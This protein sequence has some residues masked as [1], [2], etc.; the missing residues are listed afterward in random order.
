MRSL[1]KLCALGALFVGLGGFAAPADSPPT[2]LAPPTAS[3][4][5]TP[6]APKNAP[7][8]AAPA[9]THA[10]TADD[11]GAYFDGF[12][13]DAIR[14]GDVAGAVV[15]VVKDGQPLFERG[16]G[17][18]DVKTRKP[19]D[20]A[21]TLFRPGSISKT[22]TWTAVMQ[23]VQAGK[24]DL[25]ADINR[26][27]D[28][29]VPAYDGK[30][31]TMRQLMTHSP[32]FSD[33]A[34]GLIITDPKR[35]EP[36]GAVLKSAVPA[37]IFPPGQIPAYSNYGASLAGYIVE[38]VSGEPFDQYV[39]RH[40]FAPLGM[41]H[42]TFTQPLPAPFK[43]D[44]AEGYRVASAPAGKFEIVQLAPAGSLSASGGDMARFMIAQLND[45]EYQ[46]QRILEAKTAELMH[47][48]Q[49]RPVPGLPAMALGFYQEPGNGHRVIGH[50]GDLA[51]F[52]SDM[53]LYLDDHV[54][55]FLSF[56]SAGAQAAAHTIRADILRSFTARYIAPPPP[57]EPT[58]ASAKADAK[59][60][61]GRYVDTRRSDTGW[62]RIAHFLLGQG[63]IAADKDGV[64]TVSDFRGLNNKPK[65]W[66]EVGPFQYR[67]VGGD[68]RM[69]A[70]VENGKVGLVMT[71]DLPPVLALTPVSPVMS[72]SWNTPLFYFSLAVILIAGLGWPLAAIV[73][74]RYGH[75]FQLAGRPAMLY[76]LT[77]LTCAVDLLCVACW[78]AFLTYVEGSLDAASGATDWMLRGLQL[79]GVLG[80]LGAVAAVLNAATILRAG[81][82]GWWAKVSSVLIAA[83]C[84]AFVWFQLSL[85]LLTFALAY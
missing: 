32:G 59:T 38:R 80:A 25:D 1:A 40:I 35:L 10:L 31:L 55:L 21:T 2:R 26:Y 33:Q 71:D 5:A 68:S 75:S 82:R 14:R 43:P 66:R 23:Q 15:V 77:R 84:L 73:R 49:F 36:L 50:A 67:E 56:N 58:A 52:H 12:I 48:P 13:P 8:P 4:P 46:G 76:R 6:G 18:A 47:S 65:H 19:V 81:D 69:A 3:L 39:A 7:T 62:L 20:P 42:S 51:N 30:P 34:K 37:R 61:A 27:L 72:A 24:I 16:Y 70:T 17:W 85:H 74:R 9:S 28:F 22:F 53:H 57:Q 83:A 44:M 54:G 11:V 29:K 64:V 60:L 41:A 63:T 45:G 79:L 78:F